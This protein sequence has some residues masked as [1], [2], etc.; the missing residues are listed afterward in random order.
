MVKNKKDWFET[1]I[2]VISPFGTKKEDKKTKKTLIK[3]LK[4]NLIIERNGKPN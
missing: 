2:E 3:A 1:H 4:A